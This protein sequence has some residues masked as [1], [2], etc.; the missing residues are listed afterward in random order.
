M[1]PT[2]GR[3]VHFTSDGTDVRA[4]I[5]THVWS[6]SCVNLS[7]FGPNG[8]SEGKTSVLFAEDRTQAQTWAWPPRTP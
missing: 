3:I 2:I 1:K 6:D 5:I 4:A 8:D 7:V